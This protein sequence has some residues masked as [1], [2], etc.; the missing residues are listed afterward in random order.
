MANPGVPPDS[1]RLHCGDLSH[2]GEL[3]SGACELLQEQL[4]FNS[5]QA[6]NR[7]GHQRDLT[8]RQ[9]QSQ[10]RVFHADFSNHAVHHAA[11]RVQAI[12]QSRQVRVSEAIDGLLF[13]QNLPGVLT[14]EILGCTTNFHARLEEC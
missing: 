8:A 10:R 14:I 4:A 13:E 12:E 2:D 3:A 6:S 7:I 11:L 5:I 1:S 9:E